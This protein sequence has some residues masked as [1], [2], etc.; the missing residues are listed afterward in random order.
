MQ[1]AAR[2]GPA[3]SRSE[4]PRLA[5]VDRGGRANSQTLRRCQLLAYVCALSVG[6]LGSTVEAKETPAKSASAKAPAKRGKEDKNILA[7]Q[8]LLASSNR[9]EVEAGIQSLGLIG[10]AAAAP[11]IIARVRAGLPPD[12]LE[13][14]IIT[15]M[16]LGQ[17]QAGPLYI[18]LLEHRRPEVRVRAIEAIVALKPKNVE[19]ALQHTL[20]DLDPK[21][22]ASAASALG[23]LRATGSVEQL[24][25]AL[26][27]GTFEASLAIGYALR[28]DHVPRLLSYLGTLPFHHLAPAFTQVMQRKDIAEKDKLAVVSRLQEVGTREIK[29]YFGELVRESGDKL[30]DPVRRA[31]LRA[32]QEIAD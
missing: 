31:V 25:Q 23:E 15:L 17:P 9:D 24:F 29:E 3:A 6:A 1:P 2:T 10:T 4:A 22:R 12:L 19:P 7:A 32:T 8:T 13:T 30:T 16:A 11:P 26:D 20:A 21:V 14:S 5:Q 18:E 28:T 27:R